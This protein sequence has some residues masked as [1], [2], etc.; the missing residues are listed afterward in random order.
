MQNYVVGASIVNLE[1][2]EG[3]FKLGKSIPGMILVTG[4]GDTP[5]IVVFFAILLGIENGLKNDNGT[6]F[7]FSMLKICGG[8]SVVTRV[9]V[10]IDEGCGDRLFLGF[11]N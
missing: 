6:C 9:I 11:F 10:I 8:V 1:A 3:F 2:T 4:S 7:E 5:K